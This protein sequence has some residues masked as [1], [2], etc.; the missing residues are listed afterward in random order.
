MRGGGPGDA[1]APREPWGRL[2]VYVV[3][4]TYLWLVVWL[5]LWV[6]VPRVALGW[7][8]SV[9]TSGSMGPVLRAGDVVLVDPEAEDVLPGEVVTVVDPAEPDVRLTH[10]V[11]SVDVDGR[12]T[13]RGDAN[14]APDGAPVEPDA[15][16]G[17]GRVAVPSVGLPLR[18]ADDA[19]LPLAVWLVV[20][21]GAFLVVSRP[22][23]RPRQ[24]GAPDDDA[25]TG[26]DLPDDVPAAGPAWARA[27]G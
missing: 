17:V 18:W 25:R 9:L 13:T 22:V 7:E 15:V 2:A 27:P 1:P 16:I 10:R 26:P 6:L 11:V 4:C 3:A 24:D 12:L 19:P 20:T 21:A 5:L 8:P 14:P 23:P